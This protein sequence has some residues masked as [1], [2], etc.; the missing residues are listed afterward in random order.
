MFFFKRRRK[1]LSGPTRTGYLMKS[2]EIYLAD[3]EFRPLTKQKL[4]GQDSEEDEEEV[5]T[6]IK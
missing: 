6:A 2:T 1:K 4:S 5:P 3:E